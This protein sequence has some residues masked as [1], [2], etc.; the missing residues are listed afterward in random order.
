[1]KILLDTNILILRENNHIIPD[2]VAQ[3]MN[4]LNGLENCAINI[5]PLSIKEIQKDMNKERREVNLSK[6][7]AYHSLDNY[8][9]YKNDID[10][11]SVIGEAKN[12]N[13]VVKCTTD[14]GKLSNQTCSLRRYAKC[15]NNGKNCSGW[16]PWRDLR[17]TTKQYSDW[18]GAASA[19]CRAKGLR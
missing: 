10:F 19:C 5:H 8:P 18:R 16:Q 4:L 3:L 13:V 2:N 12:Q 9:D 17:D 11:T 14:T 6:L 1:M 15:S 7:N